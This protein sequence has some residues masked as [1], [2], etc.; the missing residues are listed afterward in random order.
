MNRQTSK[1]DPLPKRLA[2]FAV[3][4]AIAVASIWLIDKRAI[5]RQQEMRQQYHNTTATQPADAPAR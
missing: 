4:I 1:L 2:V 5:Q 3:L